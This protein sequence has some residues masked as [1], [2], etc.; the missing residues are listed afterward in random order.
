[1][2]HAA[3]PPPG[4]HYDVDPVN[5]DWRPDLSSAAPPAGP[6]GPAAQ[7]PPPG[8]REARVPP[9]YPRPPEAKVPPPPPL[10]PAPSS[11]FEQVPACDGVPPEV[12]RWADL[13]KQVAYRC[14]RINTGHM[15]E[16][17]QR[18]G[19]RHAIGPHGVVLFFVSDVPAEP[20][21][22]QLHT[23]YRLWLASPEADDLPRLLADL[24]EVASENIARA[25]STRRRWHPLGPDGSM[26]NGGD[27]SLPNG[28]TYVGVGVS[29][30]DSDQGH[31]Y[32]LAHTLRDLPA[33]GRRLSV[34]DL[35]GQCYVLL[36]DGT[37]MHIDRDPHARL[38][39][40]GIRCNRTLDPDRVTYF[41]RHENLTEDC[42]DATRHMWRQLGAL[43]HTLTTHLH[44]GRPV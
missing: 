2:T 18:F 28:S 25:A 36:T 17:D 9:V 6:P 10:L 8:Y 35:K 40:D 4:R 16:A 44:S 14:K 22:Y 29:T 33:T 39:V 43:N 7:V 12:R 15:V 34:F 24:A 19:Q 42:D 20:H 38:G 26:V 37:A 13:R 30:L 5:S 11:A 1:M 21:G 23:A 41:N 32:Q 31:W 3:V 27:M